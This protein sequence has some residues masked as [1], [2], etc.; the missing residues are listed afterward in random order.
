MPPA[1]CDLIFRVSHSKDKSR[2]SK[3]SFGFY[4][5][6]GETRTRGI[7]VPNQAPYQ[8]GHTRIA[9]LGDA[10]G[11]I[12]RYYIGY[13]WEMQAKYVAYLGRRG[14]APNIRTWGTIQD[15]RR[16]GADQ[17]GLFAHEQKV[18]GHSQKFRLFTNIVVVIQISLE[19][20]VVQAVDPL[21]QQFTDPVGG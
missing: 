18:V 14:T 13:L 8:L 10:E 20:L 2:E 4:G 17:S 15:R 21:R 3:C 16:G 7:L 6:S 12:P 19:I 5:P 11:T 9:P 1:Y